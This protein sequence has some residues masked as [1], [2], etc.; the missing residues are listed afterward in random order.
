MTTE[1][2]LSASEMQIAATIG[3][4]RQ[5][6]NL[7]R[8]RPDA[9]GAEQE[10]GWQ[11]HIEGAAGELAFAKWSNRFWNGNIGNLHAD[12]VGLV[13]V[14]TRSKHHYELILHPR[15]RDDRVFVLISGVT[16][17]FWIRGWIWGR[18][19]KRTEYWSDPA[20]GRPAF[21]VPTSALNPMSQSPSQEKAN[22]LAEQ[23]SIDAANIAAE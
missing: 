22:D 18:D 1:I 3:I 5:I 10:L 4:M 8:G 9:Y 6:Q 20:R 19:G 17:V 16:P 21:F 12:D 11:K 23:R 14:R 13:Q 7:D 15:D 2:T